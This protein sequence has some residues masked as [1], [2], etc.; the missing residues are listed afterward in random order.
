MTSFY[1]LSS[2]FLIPAMKINNKLISKKYHNILKNYASHHGHVSL[3][4]CQ[5]GD[6]HKAFVILH[7]QHI[8]NNKWMGYKSKQHQYLS[9][10][11]P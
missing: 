2:N 11:N 4:S 1:G 6:I 8:L 7:S 5:I 3:S 10:F 9:V